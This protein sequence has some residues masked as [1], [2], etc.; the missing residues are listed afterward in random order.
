[1]R[2]FICQCVVN[3]KV[4]PDIHFVTFNEHIMITYCEMRNAEYLPSDNIYFSYDSY[5]VEPCI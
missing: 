1:M 4:T 3:D 5:E 2:V